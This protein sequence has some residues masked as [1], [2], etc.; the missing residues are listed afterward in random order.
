MGAFLLRVVPPTSGVLAHPSELEYIFT[1]RVDSCD[2]IV[3][4]SVYSEGN[5]LLKG[6]YTLPLCASPV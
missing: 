5:L 1:R 2:A 4:I 6:S 3:P